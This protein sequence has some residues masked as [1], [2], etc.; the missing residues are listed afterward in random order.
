MMKDWD[1]DG[2]EALQQCRREFYGHRGTKE[3]IVE[4]AQVGEVGKSIE[5]VTRRP[6]LSAK[7]TNN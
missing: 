7:I 3:L 5:G 4:E 1:K 6:K 2:F